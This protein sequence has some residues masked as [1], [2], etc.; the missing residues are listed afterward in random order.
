M[1]NWTHYTRSPRDIKHLKQESQKFNLMIYEIHG[2]IIYSTA[3]SFFDLIFTSI[4]TFFAFTLVL[5]FPR[6][7]GDVSRCDSPLVARFIEVNK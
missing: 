4:Y 2:F 6:A 3:L 7:S 5:S 1:T